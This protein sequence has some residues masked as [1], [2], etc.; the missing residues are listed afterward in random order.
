MC[1]VCVYIQ[2]GQLTCCNADISQERI[3]Y[4]KYAE[5]APC[6]ITVNH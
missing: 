1:A 4:R 3:L 2:I 6:F 5:V